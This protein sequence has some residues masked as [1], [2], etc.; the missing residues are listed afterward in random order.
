MFS[1][2][3]ALLVSFVSHADAPSVHGMAVVGDQFLSHLPMFH[4]PHDYQILF[5]A[6][7]GTEGKAALLESKKLHPELLYTL[8]PETFELPAMVA[9]PKP[10]KAVL[11]RGHFE[12]GGTPIT[13]EI[14]VKL[15]KTLYFQKL[16]A[17]ALKPSKGTYLHFGNAARQYLAHFISGRPNFDQLLEIESH[18]LPPAT[19]RV[20]TIGAQGVPLKPG[21]HEAV[22][23]GEKAPHEL[24]V[25]SSLYLEF[26]DL[27]H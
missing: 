14:V 25:K 11:Y 13:R 4:S 2:L 21:I 24:R 16:R 22:A 1:I 20:I 9:N 5:E 18:W 8:V 7:L 12:R 27:A 3:A 17:E 19:T 10:F 23:E 15:K 26:G 6:D